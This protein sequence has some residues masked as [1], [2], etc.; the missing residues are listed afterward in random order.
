MKSKQCLFVK[1]INF[2]L[3]HGIWEPRVP[4]FPQVSVEAV[5]ESGAE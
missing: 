4:L 3:G 5:L 2:F 1:R